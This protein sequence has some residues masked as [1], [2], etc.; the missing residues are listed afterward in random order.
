MCRPAGPCYGLPDPPSRRVPASWS[1]TDTAAVAAPAMVVT[2]LTR[3]IR[4]VAF[5]IGETLIS[6]TRYWATWADWLE[7]PHHTVAALVGAVVAQGRDN[8]DALRLI[9][10]GLDVATERAA[11]EAAGRDPQL[12]DTDLYPDVRPALSA[13]REAGLRVVIAGNQ[14][15]RAGE[16]VR[17]LDLPADT[18][19]PQ[20]IAAADWRVNTLTDLVEAI[21]T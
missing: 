10:P 14:A 13:L 2:T 3:V 12:N 5:D 18:I 16:S 1:R 21:T 15:A 4:A 8:A 7:V 20:V 19:D 6:D 11:M 9:R 17:A